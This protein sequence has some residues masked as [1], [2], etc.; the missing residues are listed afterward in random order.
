[1]T[2]ILLSG[3][4]GKMGSVISEIVS[5][6]DNAKIICG[7]DINT[8]TKYGYPVYEKAEQ[9]NEKADVIID[10]SHPSALDGILNYA[11]EHNIPIVVATTGLTKEQME[12][13]NNASSSIPVFL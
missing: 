6:D 11:V 2:N 3:C 13:I 8:E 7:L 1:M 10:F 12:K 4:N 5:N 9:I